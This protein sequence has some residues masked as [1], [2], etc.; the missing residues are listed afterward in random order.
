[1]LGSDQDRIAFIQEYTSRQFARPKKQALSQ[2]SS[3]SPQQKQQ[4]TPPP[5]QQPPQQ[6]STQVH[7]FPSLPAT[8]RQETEWPSNINVYMKKE[9]EGDYFRR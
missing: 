3:S 5:P 4:S 7:H 6:P 9:N 2:S 1:M 8:E